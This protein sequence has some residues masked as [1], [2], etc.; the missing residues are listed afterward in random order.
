VTRPWAL[1][2]A[3]LVVA[4]CSF[5]EA[6]SRFSVRDT[7]TMTRT[8]KFAAGADRTLDVRTV[9]GE[10]HVVAADIAEVQ[11]DVRRTVRAR[12]D[13]DTADAD[14]EVTLEFLD[15]SSRVGAIVRDQGITCGDSFSRS[16]RQRYVVEYAFTVR[17]PRRTNLRLCTIN[18][19]EVTVEGTD[20][21]FDISNINGPVSIRDVRGSG[22]AET[23]NG[24][25]TVSFVEPPRGDSLFKTL[26]GDVEVTFPA[27]R[28]ADLQLKT[29]NG[30]LLT[31]FDVQTLP[32]QVTRQSRNGGFIYRSEGSARVRVGNGGP[33]L[34]FETFNGDVR[35]LKGRR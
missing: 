24:E 2:A 6:Q 1:A 31:D 33:E 20:G 30:D 19:G 8:L 34:T 12:T 13:A 15:G 35:V 5:A 22:S 10:I 27:R 3:A 14:R 32:Q 9:H 18:G 4:A 11:M 29:R 7:Q 26:N 28:S 17:V 23:I 16:G 21:D 25:M